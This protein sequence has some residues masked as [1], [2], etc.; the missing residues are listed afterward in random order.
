[1]VT[2]D[3]ADGPGIDALD[4]AD[5]QSGQVGESPAATSESGDI[6]APPDAEGDTEPGSGPEH[7]PDSP[8]A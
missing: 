4:P 8:R 1:M 2:K 6:D 5:F 7:P 3:R